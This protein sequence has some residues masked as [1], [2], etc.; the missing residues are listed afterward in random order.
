LDVH[1]TFFHSVLEEEVYMRQPL[2]FEDPSQSTYHCKLDKALYGLSLKLQAL[3]FIPSKVD[4]S[5]FIYIKGSITI[6]LQVYVDDIIITSSS[7][8]VIDAF[9]SDLKFEFAIKDMSDLHYFLGIEV[10]KVLDGVLL[11]QE[12]YTVDILRR[13][14]MASCKPAPTPL[15]SSEKLSAHHGTSLGPEACTNT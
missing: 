15:S 8:S 7:S 10:K 13:A 3:S 5:L 9:L 6:Y 11:T 12:K 1:N 14:G 4:I 2:D